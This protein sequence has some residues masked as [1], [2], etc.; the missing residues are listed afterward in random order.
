MKAPHI[1]PTVPLVSE[2]EEALRKG[3][4]VFPLKNLNGQLV[5]QIPQSFLIILLEKMQWYT[6]TM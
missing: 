2:I 5:G 1:L 3:Y 6:G 4:R